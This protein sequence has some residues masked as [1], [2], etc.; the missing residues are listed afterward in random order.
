M[1]A[2]PP[3][4]HTRRWGWS[5]LGMIALALVAP[6]ATA[7]SL[8]AAP[9]PH[10]AVLSV[11]GPDGRYLLADGW[12][13]RTDFSQTGD[14]QHWE[15]P[16]YADGFTPVAIPNAFNARRMDRNG[17]RGW[18]QWYRTRFALP[19][20]PDAVS[21][22]IRFEAVGVGATVF[23]DGRRVGSHRG[24][25]LPFEVPADGLGPGE[26]ELVVRVDGRRG[27]PTCRPPRGASA[28]GTSPGSC[29]RSTCAASRRST[30][31]T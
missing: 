10:A 16:G 24:P 18:V 11:D 23:I 3:T 5:V 15:R 12:T 14:A 13:T 8:P 25:F 19:G 1:T 4:T 7:G 22:R 21:W 27:R 9:V 26:H 20:D 6:A 30:S 29:A 17:F 2:S 28:G 31:R